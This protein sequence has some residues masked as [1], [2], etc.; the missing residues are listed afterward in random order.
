MRRAAPTSVA[1]GTMLDVGASVMKNH[2]PRNPIFG[3]RT[4]ATR[5]AT[6]SSTTSNA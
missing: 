6:S 2:A 1:I 4:S 3:Q 5:V